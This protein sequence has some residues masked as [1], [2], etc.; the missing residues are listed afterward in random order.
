MCHFAEGV[1][2]SLVC[3]VSIYSS[4]GFLS[5]MQRVILQ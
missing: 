1:G 2:F 4:S 3:N 5:G